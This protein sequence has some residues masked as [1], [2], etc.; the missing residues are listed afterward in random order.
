MLRTWSPGRNHDGGQP[1]R[2]RTWSAAL[3]ATG[4]AFSR[5]AGKSAG[6]SADI[7]EPFTPLETLYDG[8][9]LRTC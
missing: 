6:L 8:A 3:V 5:D 9:V 7:W 1:Y 4:V 2:E